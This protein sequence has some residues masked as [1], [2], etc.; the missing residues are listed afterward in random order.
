V[1]NELTTYFDALRS[2]LDL[3][4]HEE[5]E[6]VNELRA[7]VDDQ[8]A[9]LR[10]HGL[11]VREAERAVLRTL[12]RPRTMARQYQQA[13]RQATWHDAGVAAAAFLL[14]GVLFALHLW[15]Q[16]LAVITV[17]ATIV[18]ATLYGLWQG[19]PAWFYPWAGLALTL[20]TFFGYLAYSLLELS[21]GALGGGIGVGAVGLLGFAGALLY[22]PLALALLA[23]CIRAASR[24]DWLDA[25]LMLSPTAPIVAW[26]ATVHHEGGLRDAGALVAGADTALAATLLAMAGAAALFVR[27]RT[28]SAK[29]WTI[30]ATGMLALI[31]LSAIYEADLSL[32]ALMARAVL[33]FGFLF[34]PAA[35]EAVTTRPLG[36]PASSD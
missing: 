6:V 7:H 29:L 10:R 32:T 33:L 13:F 18:G 31:A 4:P 23:S 24:R 8:L 22:F 26:L 2:E 19:R 28:R 34:S 9:E 15:D 5:R 16:P 25:S 17:A 1:T 11:T 30:I 21:A 3:A 27:A 36:R 20:L 35:L 12:E 14:A